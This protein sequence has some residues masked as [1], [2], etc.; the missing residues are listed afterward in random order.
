MFTYEY[1]Y[2]NIV[3]KIILSQIHQPLN[4]IMTDL[5]YCINYLAVRFVNVQF[6][7]RVS[8]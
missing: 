1:Y 2:I 8:E 5:V 3:I 6:L 7:Y 4:H